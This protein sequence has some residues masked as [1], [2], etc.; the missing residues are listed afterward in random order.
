M[1]GLMVQQRGGHL[2]ATDEKFCIDNG[3]MIAQAGLLMFKSGQ[4]TPLEDTW[5]T[6]RYRTD[7]VYVTW[8]D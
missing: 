6:Q 2:F 7:S 3:I 5:C 4:T 1:M 8:R